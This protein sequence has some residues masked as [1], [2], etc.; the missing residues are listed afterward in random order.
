MSSLSDYD[1]LM[2]M[3]EVGINTYLFDEYEP[4]CPSED[5]LLNKVS[6]ATIAYWLEELGKL[7]LI[8]DVQPSYFEGEPQLAFRV[9]KRAVELWRDPITL[10]QLIKAILPPEKAQ[11]DIFL[12]YTTSDSHIAEELYE[13]FQKYQI[14]C[15]MAEM[16]LALATEWQSEISEALK[17]SK[18]VAIL[19]T[20]RSKSKDWVLIEVGAAWILGKKLLPLLNQVNS[21]DLI[22]PLSQFQ[23]RVVENS[24]QRQFIASEISK[25]MNL[26]ASRET[27]L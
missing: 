3:I 2:R 22:G 6:V 8:S 10:A 21:S 20:P 7:R 25:N 5:E 18:I 14:D 9:S 17:S 26:N 16:D 13:E 19:V 12:S 24:K 23:A 27:S 1:L 11:Y 4:V 15:Y